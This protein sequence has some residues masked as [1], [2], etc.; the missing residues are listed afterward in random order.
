MCICS[1]F[2]G[3]QDHADIA[4]SYFCISLKIR[5]GLANDFQNPKRGLARSVPGGQEFFVKHRLR[6]ESLLLWR[7]DPGKSLSVG[8][9][10]PAVPYN[11]SATTSLSVNAQHHMRSLACF[12]ESDIHFSFMS[13]AA[14]AREREREREGWSSV[15][16]ISVFCYTFWILLCQILHEETPYVFSLSLLS[17]SSPC[18]LL[19]LVSRLHVERRKQGNSNCIA[20]G[21]G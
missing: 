8:M 13:S 16:G 10:L 11:G 12:R 7:V 21:T 3:L 18:I 19:A 20:E 14:R 4:S 5:S 15:G 1:C 2:K 6:S 9:H 17:C